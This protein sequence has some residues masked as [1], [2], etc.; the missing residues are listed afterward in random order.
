MKLE[1]TQGKPIIYHAG[2]KTKLV[3]YYKNFL[4]EP[5]PNISPAIN[6]VTRHIPTLITQEKNEA[7]M[8]LIMQKEVDQTIQDLPTGKAPRS[9]GFT[10]EFFHSCWPMLREEVW[11]LLEESRN[12]EKVIPTL[13]ATFLTLIPKE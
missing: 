1:D 5:I 6:K 3:N 10:I 7:L 13:N 4:L 9:D 12:S 11:Q 2:M 8:T